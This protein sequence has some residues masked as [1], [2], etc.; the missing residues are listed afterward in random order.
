LQVPRKLHEK[1]GARKSFREG[2]GSKTARRCP[3]EGDDSRRPFYA[4]KSGADVRGGGKYEDKSSPLL[5]AI[6]KRALKLLNRRTVCFGR[7]RHYRT[8][9][10]GGGGGYWKGKRLTHFAPPEKKGG[11]EL[12]NPPKPEKK[13]AQFRGRKGYA[14]SREGRV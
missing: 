7:I 9:L 4:G 1:G 11:R 14:R 13:G 2:R 12:E 10:V 3:E 5:L 6:G 8:V